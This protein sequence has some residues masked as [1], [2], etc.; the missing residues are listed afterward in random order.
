[1]RV[2]LSILIALSLYGAEVLTEGKFVKEKKQIQELKAELTEFYNKKEKEYQERKAE[3]EALLKT[4]KQQKQQMQEIYEKNKKL[5][6]DIEGK[7]TNKTTLIYNGMKPKVAAQIFNKMI[8]EGKIDDVFAIIIKLKPKKVTQLMKFMGA[9]N[10]SLL[11][12]MLQN[13]KIEQ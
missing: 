12:Q 7:V 8:D 13:F 6:N 10:A 2:I 5:I 9:E 4:I 1:M 3:L 11:T